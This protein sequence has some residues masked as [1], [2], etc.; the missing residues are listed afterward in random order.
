MLVPVRYSSF[1]NFYPRPPRGGRRRKPGLGDKWFQISIHALREEGDRPR[2]RR[3]W[4]RSNFYPRP[5]RGGRPV[6]EVPCIPPKY[7]YPRPPRGG[8]RALQSIP[9]NPLRFLSTPSARR[10][11]H[12]RPVCK[13]VIA[14]SIHALREEGDTPLLTPLLSIL[15]S[16]HALREEGDRVRGAGAGLHG[17]SIHALREEGDPLRHIGPLI[18]RHFYPRPPR[19]GRQQKQRQNLYFLINYTTFCTNLEEP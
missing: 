5:P 2:R 16:I 3:C 12:L 8:R 6:Q 19:G 9:Q 13:G 1:L 4:R 15:I 11:T 14:I 18:D 10:A 17:I 7:F